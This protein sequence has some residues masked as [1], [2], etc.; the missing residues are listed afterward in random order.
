[1]SAGD[2]LADLA[3]LRRA[4]HPTDAPP[5]GAAWNLEE[6][7]DLLPPER[8]RAPA[9]VLVALYPV[10]AWYGR[11]KLGKPKDSLWRMF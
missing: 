4:L 2:P 5:T 9:A 3:Q 10:C 8:E 1:M 7:G 11:F 6:L